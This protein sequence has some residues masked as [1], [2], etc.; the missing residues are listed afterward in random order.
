MK[1]ILVNLKDWLD[2][3]QNVDF[4]LSIKGLNITVFPSLPYLY[5]YKS[6]KVRIGS[7]KISSY[8]EGPHTGSVSASHLKD[9]DVSTVIL[10][11]RE[12]QIDEEEKLVAKIKNAQKYDIETIICIGSIKEKELDKIDRVLKL[13]GSKGISIAF[14][15][16]ET[17][18]LDEIKL[19]LKYIKN[20]LESYNLSYIYGNNITA[21][22]VKEYDKVLDV[23]GFLISSHALE[24]DNLKSI[25]NQISDKVDY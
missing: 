24:I 20:K 4:A 1:K 12:C 5:V 19:S 7:Q 3:S 21:E 8:E 13:T 17:M 23:D 22:N 16:I 14:E 6:S 25:I 18:A 11:H 15:P 10:N 9:F 2:Y